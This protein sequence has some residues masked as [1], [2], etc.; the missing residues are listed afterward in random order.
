MSERIEA[1]AKAMFAW[2]NQRGS[3]DILSDSQRGYWQELARAAAAVLS[4][5]DESLRKALEASERL[6]KGIYKPW[7]T[8]GGP[9]ECSHGITNALYCQQ[10][11]EATVKAALSHPPAPR[12]DP[13]MQD[14]VRDTRQE[15]RLSAPRKCKCGTPLSDD[16]ENCRHPWQT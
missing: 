16:C 13:T 4:G 9:R 12:M 8:A 7:A 2:E 6:R 15:E 11:D 5:P 10:C 3:W 1:M 14:E